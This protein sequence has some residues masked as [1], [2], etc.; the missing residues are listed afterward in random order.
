MRIFQV[1]ALYIRNLFFNL[2]HHI[3]VEQNVNAN[4]IF[5]DFSATKAGR[6]TG[7]NQFIDL[8]LS[9]IFGFGLK[10][11]R[12]QFIDLIER[13]DA[14]QG[15]FNGVLD[16]G[17]VTLFPEDFF[18]FRTRA[19]LLDCVAEFRSRHHEFVDGDTALVAGTCA[20]G[21]AAAA[22]ELDDTVAEVVALAPRM[23]GRKLILFCALRTDAAH[24]A[25]GNDCSKDI[26]DSVRLK[27]KVR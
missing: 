10:N 23:V 1:V 6:Y 8:P 19:V 11:I 20:V 13:R 16:V 27:S 21:A 7:C 26:A 3:F 24:K 22:F 18:D 25:L 14:L 2:R 5:S 17:L 12:E 9:D 15:L 4:R